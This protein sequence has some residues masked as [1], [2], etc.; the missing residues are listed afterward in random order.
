[1]RILIISRSPWRLDNSFGNTYSSIFRD[2]KDVE[3]AN[4]Y[5][6]DGV[7]EYEENVKAYYQVS[8][9]ELVAG[10]KQP[11]S[12]KKV[13][14]VVYAKETSN[15][16]TK[17]KDSKYLALGKT[18]RWPIMFIVRDL[19]WKF[20][21]VD[22]A[23]ID[24]FVADFKPS[25]IFLP[26]YY[27]TYVFRVALHLQK[28]FNLPMTGEACLDIYSLKQLSLDPFFWINRIIIRS[29]IRKAAKHSAS[30]YLISEKMRRDFQKYLK[31]P[32]KILYKIPDFSRMQNEYENVHTPVRFLFT[33]NIGAN[34]WKSLRMLADALQRN[35]FGHL[36]IY[37]AT[38][39]TT[40]MKTTLNVDGYSELHAPVTQDEVKVLQNESDVLVH[41]ESFDLT[42]RLMV[43]Y[44]ISTKIMDYLCVG[45][46]ILGIG[47]RD[48]ASIEYLRDNDVAMIATNEGEL[49]KIISLLK[50][51]P[52]I[53]KKNSGKGICFARSQMD[54]NEMKLS[55]YN[56]MKAIIQN[57]EQAKN[58]RYI[59]HVSQN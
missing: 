59:S 18:K 27:A 34:R 38:P 23:G 43:R 56:D 26:Y 39:L 17:E 41:A 32:C 5:L 13:G 24:K 53:I 21:K 7:P 45:R 16:H 9:R 20:G 50:E 49:N 1:M 36:D 42:N 52:S 58:S 25:I 33:G 14:K 6:A 12:S 8:E 40:R 57:Y 30:L 15:K 35:Q 29:W 2:M 54:A 28:K 22:Y 4:I 47:P 55:L 11:F 3:I 46:T 10:F 31:L 44:S 37:T 51:S 48:I 19:I